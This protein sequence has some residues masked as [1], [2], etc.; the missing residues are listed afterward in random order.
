MDIHM[1]IIYI[2]GCTVIGILYLKTGER[3]SKSIPEIKFLIRC[4]P[5]LG[6]VLYFLGSLQTVELSNN[7]PTLLVTLTLGIIFFA[8]QGVIE[9]HKI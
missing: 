2:V 3:F 4:I 5:L 8:I 6:N 1:I 9:K 7:L